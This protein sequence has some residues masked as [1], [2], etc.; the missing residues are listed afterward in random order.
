MSPV[1]HSQTSQTRDD[2]FESQVRRATYDPGL[3]P[4]V[5]VDE[6]HCN[7]HTA[8]GRYKPFAE[9]LRSDGLV[10]EP[11]KTA[12]S[13]DAL[14]GADVLVIANALGEAQCE[15]WKLPTASAFRDDE[16]KALADWVEAGGALLLIADHMPFPGANERLASTFGVAFTDGYVKPGSGGPWIR[17]DRASGTLA[18][19]P[20]TSG[21]SAE[22]AIDSVTSFTGQGFRAVG[23]SVTPL[24]VHPAGTTNFLP[25]EAGQFDDATPRFSAEGLLQGALVA[26]GKGRVAVFGEAAMFSAQEIERNGETFKFGMNADGAEHNAQF[27]LNVL[28]WLTGVLEP[29]GRKP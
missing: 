29:P 10:V 23:E 17:F 13:A 27:L 26:H 11:L 14:G 6:H 15:E 21:R 20:V 28:H 9:L 5:L 22:E 7:F 18:D 19:H 3:A 2:S 24:L 16:I 25:S 4:R 8:G 12:F 1:A